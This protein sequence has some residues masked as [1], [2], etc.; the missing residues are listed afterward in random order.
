[1]QPLDARPLAFFR[2]AVGLFAVVY[3]A[4]PWPSLVSS[5]SF[6]PAG[7][8]TLANEPLAAWMVYG[9]YVG[10]LVT[11]GAFTLDWRRALSGPVF[12]MLLLWALRYSSSWGQIFHTE[13]LLVLHVIVLAVVPAADA[14][15]LDAR[16]RAKAVRDR[17]N[18]GWPLRLSACRS[19]GAS[20]P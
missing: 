10:A 18:Y 7:V 13:N 2:I 5:T 6:D 4:S 15:S 19:N 17:M 16:Q 12:A 8:V 14:L 9:L 20:G 1:M 3:L 11:G